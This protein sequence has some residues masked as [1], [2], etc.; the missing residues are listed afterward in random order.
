VGE[1]HIPWGHDLLT[2]REGVIEHRKRN[3]EVHP[4]IRQPKDW[5][6]DLLDLHVS[7]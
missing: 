1:E 3:P 6:T 4:K 2:T 7:F 5:Y